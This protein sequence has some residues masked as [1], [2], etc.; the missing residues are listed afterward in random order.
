[1]KLPISAGAAVAATLL[2]AGCVAT[3]PD[4][5]PPKT[6]AAI[7]EPPACTRG[8]IDTERA[9][10]LCSAGKYTEFDAALAMMRPAE[11]DLDIA[12]IASEFGMSSQSV[13]G[14]EAAT[15]SRI[16]RTTPEVKAQGTKQAPRTITVDG[17]KFR[18]IPL[19]ADGK[20]PVVLFVER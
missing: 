20:R 18:K 1:M 14:I 9:F 16:V 7:V 4:F 19:A 6:A 5:A 11:P 3:T 10:I 8:A 13:T 15:Y 12:S 2:L 17:R